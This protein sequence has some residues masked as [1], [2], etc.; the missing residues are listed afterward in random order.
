M[1]EED[2]GAGAGDAAAAGEG[3][4]SAPLTAE[5]EA[6]SAAKTTADAAAVEDAAP[7]H[8]PDAA[9]MALTAAEANEDWYF[10]LGSSDRY[11]LS[12]CLAPPRAAPRY[13]TLRLHQKASDLEALCS[14]WCA[15]LTTDGFVYAVCEDGHLPREKALGATRERGRESG[16]GSDGDGGG[17][18]SSLEPSENSPRMLP[19]REGRRVVERTRKSRRAGCWRRPQASVCCAC[20]PQ[21]AKWRCGNLMPRLAAWHG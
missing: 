5:Q 11:S 1:E 21:R 8:P 15:V 3:A 17:D 10:A 9:S 14:G 2:A 19:M 13:C 12:A 20:V 7:V 16:S 18:G 6:A 4:Q